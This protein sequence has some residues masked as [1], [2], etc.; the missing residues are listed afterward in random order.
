MLV[1]VLLLDLAPPGVVSSSAALIESVIT[2]PVQDHAA[3]DVAG[4]APRRSG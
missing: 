1:V 3:L 4:G 2:L